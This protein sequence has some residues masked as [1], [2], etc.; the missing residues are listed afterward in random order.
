[1]LIYEFKFKV[2]P[3]NYYYLHLVYHFS[4]PLIKRICTKGTNKKH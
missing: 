1:M 3:E 2:K 4:M